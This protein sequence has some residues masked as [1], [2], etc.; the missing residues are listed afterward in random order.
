[1]TPVCL[2]ENPYLYLFNFSVAANFKK[3]PLSKALMTRFAQDVSAQNP[4]G[5]SCIT[6]SEDGVR[7]AMRFGMKHAGSVFQSSFDN[8]GLQITKEQLFGAGDGDLTSL[9]EYCQLSRSLS[10][11]V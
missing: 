4:A 9:A 1:M 7:T 2:Q 10:Q 3:S 5:L 11:R 8:D 6:V